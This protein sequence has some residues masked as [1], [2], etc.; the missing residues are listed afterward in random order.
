[1]NRRF[2]AVVVAALLR[3]VVQSTDYR[4]TSKRLRTELKAIVDSITIEP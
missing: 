3:F 1:M 2:A 4:G